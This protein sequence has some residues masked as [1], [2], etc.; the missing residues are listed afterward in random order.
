NGQLAATVQDYPAC[1]YYLKTRNDFPTLRF[2]GEAPRP[3]YYVAFVRRGDDNLRKHLNEAIRK[4]IRSGKLKEIYEKYG[5]WTQDQTQLDK[6]AAEWPPQEKAQATDWS[7]VADFAW[8]L[9][10]AAGVT[11][12]LTCISMPL[13]MLIGLLVAVGRLY[14]PRGVAWPL[15]VYVEV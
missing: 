13:A 1:V 9:L 14:L 12:L 8:Q 5:I 4:A 6:S 7:Q 10:Q 3:G 15:A 2:A 11:V